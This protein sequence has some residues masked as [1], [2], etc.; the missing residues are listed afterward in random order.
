MGTVACRTPHKPEVH[1]D[2]SRVIFHITSNGLEMT[3]DLANRACIV[4][5][6]KREKWNPPRFPEGGLLDHVAANRHR[7]LGA[8]F[9]L[10]ALWVEDGRKRTEDTRAPGRFREWGQTLDWIVQEL[11][12]CPPLLDGHEQVQA[13]VASPGLVWVR[14]IGMKIVAIHPDRHEAWTASNLVEFASEQGIPIPGT[15]DDGDEGA[16]SRGVGRIMGRLFGNSREVHADDI[17]VSREEAASE[18]EDG[19]GT[20]ILK[21]Y[22]FERFSPQ[23]PQSPQ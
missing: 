17:L 5:I 7:F 23:S 13:R 21:T 16:A 11:A 18:R 1:I 19:N 20:R 12:G 10:V 6:R 15:K 9:H 4:R 14:D 8:I 2:P 3:E 22:R